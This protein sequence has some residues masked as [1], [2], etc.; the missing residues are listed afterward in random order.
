[1]IDSLRRPGSVLV[2][3]PN[4]LT[5]RQIADDLADRIARGE[6]PPGTML[7]SYA[8]L[9]VM[10]SVSVSTAQGALRLLRDRGLTR[11]ELGIGTFVIDRSGDE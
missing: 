2:V 5:Y 9:A 1:M 3:P 6:Y 4:R 8:Q 7:P 10:Y 11:S